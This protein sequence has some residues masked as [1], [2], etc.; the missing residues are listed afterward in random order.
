VRAG[1]LG[2]EHSGEAN[3]VGDRQIELAADDDDENRQRKERRDGLIEC[4][5]AEIV[6]RRKGRRLED[7]EQNEEDHNQQQ[8]RVPDPQGRR[9][10]GDSPADARSRVLRRLRR[11]SLLFDRVCGIKRRWQD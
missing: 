6:G 10:A 11:R 9:A 8:D 3:D 7:R 1:Q 4:D 5:T 2:R